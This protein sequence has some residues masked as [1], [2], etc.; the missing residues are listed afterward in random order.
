[1]NEY[2][3][4]A[5]AEI[6]E[7]TDLRFPSDDVVALVELTADQNFGAIGRAI[8]E[9][10]PFISVR[11]AIELTLFG[12]EEIHNRVSRQKHAAECA[13]WT[14]GNW[15]ELVGRE[16]PEWVKKPALTTSV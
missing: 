8:R 11:Q 1:M 7:R 14:V 15:C 5:L 12:L 6:K 10:W 9:E 3:K 13:R 4:E 2:V 16:K